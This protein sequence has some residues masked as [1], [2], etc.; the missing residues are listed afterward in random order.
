VRLSDIESQIEELIEFAYTNRQYKFLVTKFGTGLAGYKEKEIQ[1][2]WY[3]KLIPDN[4]RF[5]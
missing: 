3:R 1:D 4:I 2:I 5:V